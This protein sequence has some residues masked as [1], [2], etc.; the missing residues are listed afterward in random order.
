MIKCVWP[1]I[2]AV[3]LKSL[4]RAFKILLESEGMSYS[5]ISVWHVQLEQV[6]FGKLQRRGQTIQATEELL[7]QWVSSP[8]QKIYPET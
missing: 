6:W 1:V 8:L 4:S 2:I 5:V 7:E 3:I